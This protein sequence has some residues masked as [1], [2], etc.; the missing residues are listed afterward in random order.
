MTKS[1]LAPSR[2]GKEGKK[3]PVVGATLDFLEYGK[4]RERLQPSKVDWSQTTP[5]SSAN[6]ATQV[7]AVADLQPIEP[8]EVEE[9]HKVEIETIP[10]VKLEEVKELP[11]AL[12]EE[13]LAGPFVRDIIADS[14]TLSPNNNVFEQT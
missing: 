2:A 5:A 3:V 14:T 11:A 8:V 10:E 12:V 9:S 13:D 6:I 7:H 4:A 1:T